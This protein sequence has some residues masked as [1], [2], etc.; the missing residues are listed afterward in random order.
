MRDEDKARIIRLIFSNKLLLNENDWLHNFL[1]S[2]SHET[3]ILINILYKILNHE[4]KEKWE[5]ILNLKD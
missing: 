2:S 5:K 1:D 3:K 4:D